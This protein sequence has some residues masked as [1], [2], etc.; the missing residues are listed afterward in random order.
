MKVSSCCRKALAWTAAGILLAALLAPL[1]PLGLWSA[2][3]RWL[4]PAVLP[5]EWGSRAWD[6]LLSPSAQLGRALATSA[7][8]GCAVTLLSLLV[9]I[10]AGR[11]L[12]L[13]PFRGKSL[14]Q[15]LILAPAIVPGFAAA[16]GV[17]VV[18]IRYGLADTVAGVVLVQL[19]PVLPYV[20][21]ILSGVFANYKVEAEDEAR[22]LGARPWQVLFYVTL[23]A[24][25]PGVMAAG[26]F[27]FM[28]SWG[29]YLLTLLIGGGRVLTLPVLLLNFVNS[30]DYALA[31]A[32]SLVLI[33]P[34]GVILWL[35]SRSLTGQ[36]AA[37]GGFGRL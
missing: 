3:Q 24:V 8:T 22:T 2:S 34:A 20:V 5:Q 35:T 30:G 15:F 36:S 18:F 13:Y 6:Y 14:V 37:L 16:M 21:L 28:I 32:L 9:G 12:G 10:P 31:S 26:L 7:F 19:I 33:L 1:V 4:F 17:H 25:R 23:P 27:A 29:Q 11:A